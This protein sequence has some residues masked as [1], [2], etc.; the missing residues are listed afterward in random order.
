[1][2]LRSWLTKGISKCI[3]LLFEENPGIVGYEEH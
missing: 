3:D 2:Q 1:V